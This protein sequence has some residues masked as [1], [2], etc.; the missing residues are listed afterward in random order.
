MGLTL[1]YYLLYFTI[2]YYLLYVGLPILNPPVHRV[3]G[4]ETLAEPILPIWQMRELRATPRITA[5]ESQPQ[6]WNKLALTP[7][8][9]LPTSYWPSSAVPNRGGLSGQ[10]KYSKSPETP[11][12]WPPD[13]KNWLIGKDPDAGKIEGRRRRGRQRMRWLDGITDLMDMSLGKLWELVMDREAWRAA[14]HGVT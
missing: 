6:A 11:I 3:T 1:L 13:A 2:P 10:M 7:H 8:L 14:I 12:L 4:S 9:G 5:S